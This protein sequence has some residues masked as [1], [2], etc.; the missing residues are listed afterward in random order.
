MQD[1]QIYVCYVFCHKANPGQV[2]GAWPGGQGKRNVWG[3][4]KGNVC[5]GTWRS[6]G[7]AMQ[8]PLV[9]KH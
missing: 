9:H 8:P 1:C 6:N 7:E 2:K 4:E 3:G 5:G